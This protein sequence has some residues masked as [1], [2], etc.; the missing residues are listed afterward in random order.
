MAGRVAVGEMRCDICRKAFEPDDDV[1][2]L[3]SRGNYHQSCYLK[4]LAPQ[5]NYTVTIEKHEL[6]AMQELI[7]YARA[8][9]QAFPD[10]EGDQFAAKLRAYATMIEDIVI[11]VEKEKAAP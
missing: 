7:H 1:A 4:R 8:I 5:M 2:L 9:A 6:R 3:P 11:R 10:K